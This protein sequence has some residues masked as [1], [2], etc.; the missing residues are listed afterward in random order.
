M[1]DRRVSA[2]RAGAVTLRR[3]RL[4]DGPEFLALVEASRPF[5]AGL[6]EPPAGEEAFA[7][8]VRRVADH[9]HDGFL[10]L[11]GHLIGV[12]NLNNILRGNSQSASLGYYRLAAGGGPTA[13]QEAVGAVVTHAFGTLRLHRLEA[14]VQPGNLRSI[15]LIRALGFRLEGFAPGF[16]RIGGVWRDHERWALLADEWIA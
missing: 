9:A 12:V 13:M 7:A 8:Y 2:I 16:L 5:H 14:N 11:S 15:E 3:P 1:A 10:V 4:S 6:V